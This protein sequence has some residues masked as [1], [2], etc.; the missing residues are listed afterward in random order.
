MVAAKYRI[1]TSYMMTKTLTI[2]KTE[3]KLVIL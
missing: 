2:P 1:T 3:V